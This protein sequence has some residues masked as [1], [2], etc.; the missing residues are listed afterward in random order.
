MSTPC[1]ARSR[2]DC[3]RP[4]RAA[5]ASGGRPAQGLPRTPNTSTGRTPAQRPAIR[6]R[7][8]SRAGDQPPPAR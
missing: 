5:T 2:T 7:S 4:A 3:Q 6:L 1:A 8:T